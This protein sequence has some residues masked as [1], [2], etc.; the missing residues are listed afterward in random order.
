LLISRLS[1]PKLS[2]EERFEVW[3]KQ[4]F[5]GKLKNF[6]MWVNRS[7]QRRELLKQYVL[8][9]YDEDSI[10]CL[11][12]RVLVDGGIRWNSAYAMIERA[13]KLRRAIDLFFP[14]YTHIGKEYDIQGGDQLNS[15]HHRGILN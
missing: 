10:E 3:R 6:C 9:A 5:I 1:L 8:T 15:I 4:S 13:L 12:T 11:Y 14:N 2:D 7:D